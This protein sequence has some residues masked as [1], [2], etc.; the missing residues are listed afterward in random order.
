MSTI[1][2]LFSDIP[3]LLMRIPI[4][5]LAL[6]AHEAAHGYMA[7]RLGDTTAK[8]MGRL[9]LN[10]L[11]HLDPLG[12]IMM[13]LFGFGWARPVPI[14]T[15][16][17]KKPK[18]DMALTA[19]AGPISNLLLALIGVFLSRLFV[20][21][22]TAAD[23]VTEY[24]GAQYIMAE[25]SFVI[26]LIMYTAMFLELFYWLNVSLAIFNLLPI[27]PLDGSRFFLTFLPTR[28]YFEVMRYEHIIRIVL[29][30]ALWA[31]FLDRPLR[32]LVMLVT[33]AMNALVGLIPFL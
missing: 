2:Q 8:S 19:I 26:N 11:K 15:R 7:Y 1:S 30:V 25:S 14:M 33:G 9:T 29:L 22:L 20:A 18:R 10:P 32:Y 6:S 13:F 17:F 3:L 23:V 21:V 12:T 24:N 28:L 5:L 4:V 27:P 16:H 31:G